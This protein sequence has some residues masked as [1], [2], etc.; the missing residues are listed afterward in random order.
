M[1]EKGFCTTETAANNVNTTLAGSSHNTK[2]D[3]YL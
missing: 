1:E 3:V 2:L